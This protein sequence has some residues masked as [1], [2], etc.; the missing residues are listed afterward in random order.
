MIVRIFTNWIDDLMIPQTIVRKIESSTYLKDT[1]SEA[2]PKTDHA[3]ID[4][5]EI[6]YDKIDCVDKLPS[7]MHPFRGHCESILYKALQVVVFH[8]VINMAKV[9]HQT[10]FS[11]LTSGTSG[12]GGPGGGGGGADKPPIVA[13]PDGDDDEEEDEEDEDDDS[14]SESTAE[15]SDSGLEYISELA[16]T[17]RR[18]KIAA[19]KWAVKR[20]Y[21]FMCFARAQKGLTKLQRQQMKKHTPLKQKREI[22]KM[23]DQATKKLKKKEKKEAKKEAKRQAKKDTGKE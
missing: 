8:P 12:S 20:Y 13:E 14:T 21:A 6:D 23:L 15:F 5:A 11:I 2:N 3:E 10:A 16:A 9:L 1:Q 18:H 7:C 19:K 22:L 17:W 4:Y